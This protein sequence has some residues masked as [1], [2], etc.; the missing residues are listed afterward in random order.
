[1]LILDEPTSVLTLAES[2]ELFAVLRRVVQEEGRAVILISHKLDE[3]LDA[4]DRV[5]DH[6][7]RRGVVARA[8]RTRPTR[9]SWPRRDGRPRGVVA[10]AAAALGDLDALVDPSPVQP[11][12]DGSSPAGRSTRRSRRASRLRRRDAARRTAGRC[13]TGC[14]STCAAGEIV[15]LAGVEGNGQQA[16]RLTLLS[17]LLAPDSGTVEIDGRPVDV[18]RPGAMHSAGIGVMPEDRHQSGLRARHVASP[19]TS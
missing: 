10:V 14:P 12:R 6:A 18:G 19:R 15:G 2:R 17:S 8:R 11:T 13:S 1:M 9:A 3:I 16:A 5:T 4:T 7:R